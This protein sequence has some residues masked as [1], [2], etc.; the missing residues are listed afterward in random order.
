MMDLENGTL[1]HG[2]AV[3]FQRLGITKAELVITIELTEFT[4]AK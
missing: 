4:S 3:F 2:I 1:L